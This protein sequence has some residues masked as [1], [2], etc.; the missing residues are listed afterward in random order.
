MPPGERDFWAAL[1]SRFHP[2]AFLEQMVS[3]AWCCCYGGSGGAV[4]G[5]NHLETAKSRGLM[6]VAKPSLWLASAD[7]PVNYP[8][9]SRLILF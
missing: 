2:P 9:G 5:T 1:S 4:T 7:A 8:P 6:G 3:I